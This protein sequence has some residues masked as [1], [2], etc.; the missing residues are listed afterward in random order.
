MKNEGKLHLIILSYKIESNTFLQ[1]LW[2]LFTCIIT[3]WSAVDW[4]YRLLIKK[5]FYTK[6]KAWSKSFFLFIFYHSFLL[7]LSHTYKEKNFSWIKKNNFSW[8]LP[9]VQTAPAGTEEKTKECPSQKRWAVASP[10][11][12]RHLARG[13]R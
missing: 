9:S 2:F 7:V 11:P 4:T 1:G 8:T 12:G 3:S 6:L 10:A 5:T 13:V